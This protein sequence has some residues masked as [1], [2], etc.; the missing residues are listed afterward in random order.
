MA[1]RLKDV[2]SGWLRPAVYL[3]HNRITALGAILTTSSAITL[4]AF[5][6]YETTRGMGAIHPYGGL[7]FFLMLPGVFVIGLALIPLGVWRRWRLLLRKHEL[8]V[9]YPQIDLKSPILQ[10]GLLLV[11]ALTLVNVLF[12]GVSG[13]KGIEYMDSQK[14]C[15]QTCHTVMDPE[16]VAYQ[17]S[18]HSRV[19]CVGCHIGP[20]ASWFVKSKM[21]G[22][23]QVFAVAFKTYSRP[24]PS[25]VKELRPARE[26]CEQCH[27]PQRFSGDKFIVR[28]RYADDERNTRQTTVLVLKLGGR[29]SNGAV[30]IHGRHIDATERIGYIATD[31]RRQ[32]IPRVTYRDDGGKTVEF[33]STDVKVTSAELAK[34]E[35]RKMDCVDCH[36]RP[37]HAFELPERAVDRRIDQGL[38]SRDL[39][40]VKKKAVELLKA[41]YP[42]RS[43][44]AEKIVSALTEFYRTQYPEVYRD[45]RAA[46]ESAA[47]AVRDIY[48][49]NIFPDMKIAW[50]THPNN[51]GHEDFLGCFRCHDGNHV[52]EGGKAIASDCDSC[53][54]ILAQDETNPKVLAQLGVQ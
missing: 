48:L 33:A 10:R 49:R 53:H 51:I 20:G 34:G 25:P 39:P 19:E 17:N 16:Y 38:V 5:W 36:N 44:A 15:G 11:A 4:V 37:T 54:N 40:F 50:G 18:P 22:L 28:R 26:T 7:V 41:D 31:D 46:V 6:I 52:A 30:G 2:V 8:P 23:R 12:M 1:T 24:I 45:H 29:T 21:S 9:E 35:S 32:V 43:V 13:Y 14:F 3:G 27:W 42:S 47:D